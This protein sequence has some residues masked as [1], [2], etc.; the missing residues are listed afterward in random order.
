MSDED[1]DIDIESDVS[2]W[3]GLEWLYLSNFTDF[4]VTLLTFLAPFFLGFPADVVHAN[5]GH[6]CM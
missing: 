4:E 6:V 3:F 1:R 2:I 5:T